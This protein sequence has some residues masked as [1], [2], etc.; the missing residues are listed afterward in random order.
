MSNLFSR[1]IYNWD[2]WGAVYQSIDAFRPLIYEIFARE[3]LNGAEQLSHLKP[4]TNA[5]FKVGAYVIKIFAPTSSGLNSDQDFKVEQLAMQRAIDQGVRTPNIVSASKIVDKY[6]FKYIIMDY[7][8]GQSAETVFPGFKLEQKRKFIGELHD[9]MVKLNTV[10]NEAVSCDAIIEKSICNERW[11]VVSPEVKKQIEDFLNHYKLG[12]CV[13][14]H[15]DLT[16]DNVLIDPE[17]RIYVIDFADSTVAPVEYEYPGIVFE[18][19]QN[20]KEGVHEFMKCRNVNYSEFINLLFAGTLLHDFGGNFI[21]YIYEKYVG[22]PVGEM[23]H[24]SE[25]KELIYRNL[26]AD[27][28]CT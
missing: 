23:A 18:L 3:Q 12:N 13:Y 20:D 28:E 15:G 10:P 16:G 4:G 17:G 9:V 6:E 24:I 7:I 11:N 27:Y 26:K 2:S 1:E 19:F 25:F 8:E 14:V 21:K 22:K 5:V